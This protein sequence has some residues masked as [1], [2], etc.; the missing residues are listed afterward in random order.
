MDKYQIFF[1]DYLSVTNP[2]QI[3]YLRTDLDSHPLF[4]LRLWFYFTFIYFYFFSYSYFC[5]CSPQRLCDIQNNR[6]KCFFMTQM[7]ILHGLVD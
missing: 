5:K 3:R 4:E 7:Y 1:F 2:G 6:N